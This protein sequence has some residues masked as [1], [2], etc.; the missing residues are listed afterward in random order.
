M[1]TAQSRV[2][3]REERELLLRY[4]R[5]GDSAARDQLVTRFL[6]LARQL[7]RRYQRSSEPLEDLEQVAS[8][9]LIKAVD[10]FDP[11]RETALSSFAVPTILGELRRHF[12]DRTW[13][14]HAPRELQELSLR[15]DAAI[16]KHVAQHGCQPTVEQI[17]AL[18]AAST[19]QVL[20][21]MQVSQT[22]HAAS[23]DGAAYD[24]DEDTSFAD[25]LG[26]VDDGFELAEQRTDLQALM[27]LLTEQQREAIRLRFN[28]DLTQAEIAQRLGCSQMQVSRLLSRG[29]ARM[30]AV[31]EK[32][33]V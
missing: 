4:H 22:R 27:G 28:E 12:R 9:G 30:R 7:A 21:A 5:Q 8:V 32:Q 1:A 29:L 16:E 13:S 11:E 19:E 33:A 20:E 3:R 17:A 24:E 14:V 26:C 31:A 23:L 2:R 15:V 18:T 10:R 25:T 6:P